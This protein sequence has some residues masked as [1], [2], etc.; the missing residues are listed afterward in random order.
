MADVHLELCERD[1]IRR[2]GANRQRHADHMHAQ[3]LH[4]GGIQRGCELNLI[5]DRIATAELRSAS[6][7]VTGLSCISLKGML[8]SAIM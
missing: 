1:G 3:L 7:K 2:A 4:H 8:W 6:A 5:E